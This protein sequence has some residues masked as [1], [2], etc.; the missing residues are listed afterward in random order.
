MP[1]TEKHKLAAI[2]FTD[3]VGFTPIMEHSEKIALELI[4]RKR[5]IITPLVETHHGK[6]LK[7]LGDGFLIMF[8]SAIDAVYCSKEIQENLKDEKELKIRIGI[9]IGDIV[10]KKDDILGSGVNIASRIEPL[11]AAGGICISE[12]VHHQIRNRS[13]INF[14]SL[15]KKE[16]KGVK[17]PV[18]IFEL[19][20]EEVI[21]TRKKKSIFKEL[22]QRRVPQIFIIYLGACWAIIEFVSSLLVDR[23][24][25]SPHLIDFSIVALL[26]LIPS[27]LLLSYFHGKPGK[28]EWTKFEKIGIPVNIILVIFILF[29][30]FQGKDLGAITKTI[31]VE[32][33]EGEQIERVIPKSE[34]RKSIG[35]FFFE[36]VSADSTLDWLQYGISDMLRYDLLQ[37]IFL[38]IEWGEDFYE[39]M[40]K[41]GFS[42]GIGLPL[43]LKKK[44]VRD[45]HLSYFITGSFKKSDDEYQIKISL[46][47]AANAKLISEKEFISND[48]FELIDEI[49]LQLKYDIKIPEIHI[50]E[51]TDL[52]ISELMTN[53]VNALK[54]YTF[55]RN[56]VMF[57]NDYERSQKYLEQSIEEDSTFAYAYARLS[58]Q[59]YFT[60]EYEKNE[61]MYQYLLNNLYRFTE[62]SKFYIK[63]AYYVFTKNPEKR[64]RVIDMWTKL[65]P[66]DLDGHYLLAYLY[67][68]SNQLD[69]AINEY[70]RIFELDPQSY[71]ILLIIGDLFITKGDFDEA[72]MYYNQYGNQFPES[73][74]SYTKIAHLYLT[75]GDY[76]NAKMFYDKAIVIIPEDIQIQAKLINIQLYQGQFDK[77][78]DL[79]LKL[80]N[81]CNN[82]QDIVTIHYSLMDYY[83]IKG[84]INNYYKCIATYSLERA[85]YDNPYDITGTK[86]FLLDEYVNINKSK[87]AFDILTNLKQDI[88]LPV[89]NFI[90]IGYLLVYL[91]MEDTTN[92]EKTLNRFDHYVQ[93]HGDH[94]WDYTINI[95]KALVYELKE[96]YDK[97]I[98]YYNEC[99]Q[100]NPLVN[101]SDYNSNIGRCYRKMKKYNNSEEHFKQALKIFQ[102][103]PKTNYEIALLYHD[104]DKDEK[105]M[106]H[107]NITLEVW[108]DADPEYIPAQKARETLKEWEG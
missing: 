45:N 84:E 31:N 5:G 7:E 61:R 99:S 30:T 106:E 33:E 11:A 56:I 93:G 48:I 104:W 68:R 76:R 58:W 63:Q 15:G 62:R 79:L 42:E 91:A 46:Y 108:K 92:I 64:F 44:I 65:Y 98:I 37:D 2:V 9:H 36:N 90:E 75:I 26:S 52:Q 50:E 107:L 43:T 27:I 96:E 47:K 16:L 86:L 12:D 100:I 18:E 83:S 13:D 72:L 66:D 97:A 94:Q 82:P 57:G 4:N 101:M 67:K 22:W 95:A 54:L 87:E 1:T 88:K 71:N 20:D 73:H 89:E 10:I 6:I 51:V 34:F 23:Y 102:F 21:L 103:N 14:I 39:E 41:A 80:L 32:N 49:S 29:F 59:Y 69:L 24:L 105:A 35:I 53:S 8:D 40:E 78:Y 74:L 25:L 17:H 85:K 55:G 19:T 28:D 60:N 81:K 70:S 77:A 38:N 3:I